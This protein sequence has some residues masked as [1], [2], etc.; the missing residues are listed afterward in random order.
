VNGRPARSGPPLDLGAAALALGWAAFAHRAL[1][2]R[3]RAAAGLG[4]AAALAA[5]ARVAGA[6]ARDLGTDRR[7]L[8][9]GL[10]SGLGAAAVV[11]VGTAAARA[12][13]RG[14]TAFSDA[15]VVD[16]SRVEAAT[17]VLVRIPFATALAEELVFRGVILGLGLRA[18]D[19]NA[20]LAISALA[21]GLWHV[22][23]ALHPE[24]Q[25]A[26]AGVV[27]HRLAPAPM[28]A[29]GDV[30]ATSIA[31]VALGWLRIRSDSIAA[32]TIAHAAL[33]G[34]AYVAT[35]FGPRP[36]SPAE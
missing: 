22:G 34:S 28:V 32:P 14:G 20:A 3:A 18:R 24:R 23:A 5:L 15:R 12:L 11:V 8:R 13:D 29:V 25:R 26:T 9:A 19:R 31:G 4:A 7:D 16:A 1:P 17:H 10:R 36:G 6:D 35:R 33:N 30:V 27:G 2:E 21:F